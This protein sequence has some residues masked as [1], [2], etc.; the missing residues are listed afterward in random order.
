MFKLQELYNSPLLNQPTLKMLYQLAT[1]FALSFTVNSLPMPQIHGPCSSFYPVTPGNSFF[2]ISSDLGIP[3][4]YLRG[5]NLDIPD[6]LMIAGQAVPAICIS[7]DGPPV[8]I[9]SPLIPLPSPVLAPL[10]DCDGYPLPGPN[11]IDQV[12]VTPGDTM[13]CIATNVGLFTEVLIGMNPQI[14][15]PNWIYPGQAICIAVAPFPT[16][17]Y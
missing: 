2:S 11:C 17:I 12:I 6:D 9:L 3:E 14:V 16:K 10:F 5:I 7:C 13:N 15:D 8:P 4:S 1:L